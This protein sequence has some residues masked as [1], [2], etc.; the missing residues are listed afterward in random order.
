MPSKITLNFNND[1]FNPEKL[2]I[3]INN[4]TK[5]INITYD[6]KYIE[7]I[8][9]F[10]LKMPFDISEYQ[11][12]SAKYKI[13][14]NLHSVKNKNGQLR[15]DDAKIARCISVMEHLNQKLIEFIYD[16]P[17]LLKLTKQQSTDLNIIKSKLTSIIK[18]K[19][20]DEG[21]IST[22]YPPLIGFN[23][24]AVTAPDENGKYSVTKISNAAGE[25]D[26]IPKIDLFT[27]K[28]VTIPLNSFY[29]LIQNVPKIS[30]LKCIFTPNIYVVAEKSGF[31]M[32]LSKIYVYPIDKTEIVA[33]TLSDD[34][35]EDEDGDGSTEEKPVNSL[36]ED[37]S[38]EEK[39]VNNPDEII[40][41]VDK[42]SV[43]KV[44]EEVGDESDSDSNS[45]G[46]DSD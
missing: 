16:N 12:G 19:Y 38:T 45:D 13:Y 1:D 26:F 34:E 40:N 7:F 32:K 11:K 23:V 46:D 37:G 9:D 42:L 35:D 31:S 2:Q 28:N 5:Y 43:A 10:P 27:N 29:D 18:Y 21:E 33:M 6:G 30:Q 4:K 22:T 39:P 44:A 36:D 8:I 20:D 25:D 24:P 15:D 3:F 17:K 41:K 14:L